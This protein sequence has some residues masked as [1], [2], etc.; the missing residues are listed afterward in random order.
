MGNVILVGPGNPVLLGYPANSPKYNELTTRFR[1][2]WDVSVASGVLSYPLELILADCK[3]IKWGFLQK[4]KVTVG[5]VAS[6]IA[7]LAAVS[8]LCG[9]GHCELKPSDA[10]EYISSRTPKAGVAVRQGV[11]VLAALAGTGSAGSMLP[12]PP[13]H[14]PPAAPAK[15]LV[16]PR[17]SRCYG[18]C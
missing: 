13:P 2:A 5:R 4:A 10:K 1:V 14:A 17:R 16:S 6:R 12:P 18:R 7:H 11:D 8:T 9:F 15:P 3:M